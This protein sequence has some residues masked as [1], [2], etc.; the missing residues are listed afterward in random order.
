VAVRPHLTE[1]TKIGIGSVRKNRDT[2]HP[3]HERSGM[4]LIQL[5]YYQHANPG[6]ANNARYVIREVLAD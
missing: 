5:P 1:P 6:M 3:D 4:A 2:A